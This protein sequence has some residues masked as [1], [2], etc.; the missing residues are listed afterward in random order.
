MDAPKVRSFR[1]SDE[2]YERFRSLAADFPNQDQALSALVSAWELQQARAV[3]TDRGTEIS[4]LDSHLQAIQAAFLH[5]LE[6]NENAEGR[7]RQ[8][9]RARLE[10]KDKIIA[11]LQAQLEQARSEAQAVQD[12]ASGAAAESAAV[13]ER[14]EAEE[15]ARQAAEKALQNAEATISDK[16]QII[17]DLTRRL[18]TADGAEARIAAA[19]QKAREADDALKQ[20]QHEIQK[21]KADIELAKEKAELA[22]QFA[23]L[24]GQQQGQ[25]EITQLLSD[26]RQMMKEIL[27]LRAEKNAD[28]QQDKK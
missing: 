1:A 2:V 17:D 16:T 27:A 8:E 14:L 9:F 26:N 6:L 25:A 23:L 4:S 3:I 20:A 22:R 12:K 21:L 10:S 28:A 19:D 11:D 13:Q 5:S 15:A 18:A 7:I 24:E